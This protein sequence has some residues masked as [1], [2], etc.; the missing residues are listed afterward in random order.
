[1]KANIIM[2]EGTELKEVYLFTS[3]ELGDSIVS[4]RAEIEE[5]L[6]FDSHKRVYFSGS[7]VQGSLIPER[8]QEYEIIDD[9]TEVADELAKFIDNNQDVFDLNTVDVKDFILENR[10]MLL[11]IL[12]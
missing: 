5:L 6:N 7:C 3:K 11:K 12:R 1:M 10:A 9:T 8:I 2:Y 4:T